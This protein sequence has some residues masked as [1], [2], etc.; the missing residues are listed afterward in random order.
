MLNCDNDPFHLAIREQMIIDPI[1]HQAFII[2]SKAAADLDRVACPWVHKGP[3][4]IW[5]FVVIDITQLV[6]DLL[7]MF[8]VG[9][10]G[11]HQSIFL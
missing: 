10:T 6:H 4:L 7:G 9:K 1:P 3:F 8:G 11:D 2:S 5:A